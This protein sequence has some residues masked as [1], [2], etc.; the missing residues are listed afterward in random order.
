MQNAMSTTATKNDKSSGF[1]QF[2]RN[3]TYALY[4]RSIQVKNNITFLGIS[5]KIRFFL[6]VMRQV[7]AVKK[8]VYVM[9]QNQQTLQ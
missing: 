8:A 1:I 4:G 9:Y 2:G 7:D 5:L 3:T 6:D